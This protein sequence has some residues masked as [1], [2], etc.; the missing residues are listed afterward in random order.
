VPIEDRADGT[1]HDDSVSV[2]FTPF[3]L[4]APDTT[5]FNPN[6]HYPTD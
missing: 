6:L 1:I 2:V 5:Y 3:L 4:M